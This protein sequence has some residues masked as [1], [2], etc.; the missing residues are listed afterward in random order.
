VAAMLYT[1]TWIV[2]TVSRTLAL[3]DLVPQCK[4]EV[5]RP[6][7]SSAKAES[8]AW[9]CRLLTTNDSNNTITLYTKANA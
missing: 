2:S 7:V 4:C 1:T 9:L 8:A 6:K 5:S 3:E